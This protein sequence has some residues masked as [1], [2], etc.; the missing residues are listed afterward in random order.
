VKRNGSWF[1][2]D[3]TVDQDRNG[4]SVKRGITDPTGLCARRIGWAGKPVAALRIGNDSSGVAQLLAAIAQVA[5][6][7]RV[8][9]C[10]EGTEGYGIG[11][12]RA[13]AAAGL[14]VIECVQ[15]SR[16]QRRGTG[17]SGP[18]DAHLTDHRRG[19]PPRA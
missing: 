7:P 1:K 17:K 12:A 15:P 6:G 16:Q 3:R 11:L 8:A 2:G 13:L 9:V 10:I 19:L 18:V 4:R 14:L 5:P